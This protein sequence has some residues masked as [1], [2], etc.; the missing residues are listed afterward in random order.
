M[1]FW[2]VS[3]VKTSF[4][5]FCPIYPT[6]FCCPTFWQFWNSTLSCPASPIVPSACSLV[7]EMRWFGSAV[8]QESELSLASIC[9]PGMILPRREYLPMSANVF[10]VVTAGRGAVCHLGAESWD[11]ANHP[12]GHRKS[13]QTKG[14]LAVGVNSAKVDPDPHWLLCCPVFRRSFLIFLE[15]LFNPFL[16]VNYLGKACFL[17]STDIGFSG[18]SSVVPF[19]QIMGAIMTQD[20]SED[21]RKKPPI[22]SVVW[23]SNGVMILFFSIV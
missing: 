8:Y 14:H 15:R 16:I 17:P 21:G 2:S 13:P 18:Y 22:I 19:L 4:L 9:S 6:A 5:G 23:I 1:L 10:L 11:A 7:L 12:P 3:L 20:F